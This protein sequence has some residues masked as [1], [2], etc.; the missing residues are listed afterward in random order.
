MSEAGRK[1]WWR[2]AVVAVLGG[3]TMTGSWIG[4]SRSA[5]PDALANPL[6]QDSA[7]TRAAATISEPAS[8]VTPTAA[9]L[10]PIPSV[11]GNDTPRPLDR[12]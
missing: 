2:A 5:P 4:L 7:W 10:P 11:D 12:P 9:T 8:D 1:R 3:L 6:P